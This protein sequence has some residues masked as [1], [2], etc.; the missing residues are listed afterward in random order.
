MI[1]KYF[2]QGARYK[3]NCPIAD[4]T[5]SKDG[6]IINSPQR[7]AAALTYD[8]MDGDLVGLVHPQS[9]GLVKGKSIPYQWL[10]YSHGHTTRRLMVG[11][12]T[13]TG[14]MSGCLI[15][16]W[17]DQGKRWVGHVGTVESSVSVNKK[18][19]DT[20]G[21]VMPTQARGFYPADAWNPGEIR[22]MMMKFKTLPQVQIMALVTTETKFYSILMFKLSPTDWCVGGIKSMPPVN[23]EGLRARLWA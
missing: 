13:L 17:T 18:V 15:C 8:G 4:T 23:A 14:P 1:E 6:S 2:I 19:K 7:P 20:F 22:P 9:V 11:G 21:M 16:E 10:V 5:G 12:D 3:W